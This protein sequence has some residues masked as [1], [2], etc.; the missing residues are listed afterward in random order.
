MYYT[1]CKEKPLLENVLF[2]G[3]SIFVK[4]LGDFLRREN[5]KYLIWRSSSL[6]YGYIFL[7]NS[8]IF[9]EPFEHILRC[10][11]VFGSYFYGE[12]YFVFDYFPKSFVFCSSISE[13]VEYERIL[14]PGEKH[15]IFVIKQWFL[16]GVCG[17]TYR[18]E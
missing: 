8:K 10:F 2:F 16:C 1:I 6:F 5:M 4:F 11:S 9:C 12:F 17:G 15:T 7:R 13:N 18:P 14:N 3:E